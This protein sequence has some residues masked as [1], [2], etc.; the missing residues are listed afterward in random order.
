MAYF[1]TEYTIHFDDTMAYGS[2]HFL[3]AFKLQCASRESFLFGEGIF[4]V[5]GVREALDSV[6]LLT[7]DAYARNL[8]P[9]RLGDRLAILLSLEEWGQASARFC[10]RVMG[11]QGQAVCAGFQTL[12]CVDASTQSPIPLP[13]ALQQAVNA[14]RDIAE[15]QAQE[16]FRKRVLS[17]RSQTETLFGEIE[18]ETCRQ[19]FLQRYPHP[20]LV[21]L[22][23][24]PGQAALKQQVSSLPVDAAPQ[25]ASHNKKSEAW[26]FGGQATF[27]AQIFCERIQAYANSDAPARQ[28]LNECREI[29]G[30]LLGGDADGLFSASEQQCMR[31][32]KS[33]PALSQVGIHLQNVL[34]AHLW[35]TLGHTPKFLLGH[36]FGEV[37]AFGVG[38]CFDL[39]T[40]VRIVC[41]RMLAVAELA[42]ANAGLLVV[43]C[44]RHTAEV[45]AALLGLDQVVF[46]GRNHNSQLVMSGPTEQLNRLK[47]HL[48]SMQVG[49]TSI[50][51]PTSFHHPQLRT[52]ASKWLSEL[53]RL[54]L[55]PPSLAIYSPISQR[56]ISSTDD[57]PALLASQLTLPFDL[58]SAITELLRVGVTSFVDCGSAG[59][60]ARLI[61][62][63]VGENADVQ[64][65]STQRAEAPLQATPKLAESAH[66][67]PSDPPEIGNRAT[68]APVETGARKT[69]IPQIAIVGAGCILPGGVSSPRDLFSTITEQRVGIVD[70]RDFDPF[71]S[72][73]FYSAELKPDRSNSHLFGRIR[74]SDIS[75][76]DGVDRHIFSRFTRTQKLLC[77]ALAPC[78]ASLQ[79]AQRVICLLGSTADGFE[80]QDEVASLRHAGIDP[81]NPDVE[82]RM[83]TARS[84]FHSPHS[85]VQEVVDRIVGPGIKVTLVDAA[86]A[87]SLY[88]LA[89]GMQA[90]ESNQ[91]DAVIAGG[92]FCPGPG[93][94][95][96][97]SQF[98]GT[99]STGCRPFDAN[100]DGVVFS[101]GAAIV[102]LRRVGDAERFDLP[103]SAIV[104][105]AG[106]SSDGRSPSANVPQSKGQLLSLE[107]CYGNYGIDPASIIAIEGHGTSTPVGDATELATLRSFF[108][109]NHAG[110]I[111]V[112]SLKGLLGHAGWA[113]GTASVI[114][115]CEYLRNGLFPS[116]ATFRQ[117]SA[118]LLESAGTL[119][120]STKPIALPPL[121]GRIAIDGFGFGGANAHVVLEHYDVRKLRAEPAKPS[122][123]S[124][125]LDGDELVIVA[126]HAERPIG[127]T[128]FE[129]DQVKAPKKFIMLPQLVDDMDISQTLAIMVCD[130][131]L[132]QIPQFDDVMR[133]ETGLLLAMSGKT[134]RGIEATLRIMT[135]RMR[136]ILH[137]N[138]Q[139]LDRLNKAYNI[140]RPSGAYTLQCMMPNVASGRA[141]LLL[142]LNGPN[143]VVDAGADSLEAAFTAAALLLGS[144]D[145]VGTKMVL[146]TAIKIQPSHVVDDASDTVDDGDLRGSE[147]AAAYAVTT[148]HFAQV[149]G[150]PVICDVDEVFR[151]NEV[152]RGPSQA[153]LR[154]YAQFQALQAAL[155]NRSRTTPQTSEQTMGAVSPMSAVPSLSQPVAAF[156]S[157]STSLS[158]TPEGGDCEIQV[159]VW[160]EKPM[161]NPA[162]ETQRAQHMLVIV[163]AGFERLPELRAALPQ[164][165]DQSTIAVVGDSAIDIVSATGQSNRIAIDMRDEQLLTSSLQEICCPSVDVV[166][167][168][169][170]A[171]SWDLQETLAEIALNNSLCELLFLIAKREVARLESGSIEM[172]GVLIDAWNG[173]AHPCS[174]PIAGL[175]KS[176][177]REFP[178]TRSGTICTQS[179]DVATALRLLMGERAQP[180]REP[181]LVFGPEF[182]LVRRL[183]PAAIDEDA[184]AQVTLDANSVVVAIGGAKGVTAVMLDSLLCEVPCT[185]IAIGRSPLE[186]GPDNFDTAEVEQT[187]YARFLRENPSSS[188]I[189]MRRS[190]EA[191][192][193]RWEAHQ[194]VEQLASRGGQV[195]YMVA[196]VTD[197]EQLAATVESIVSRF[198]KIDLLLYGAGVQKSKRLADRSLAD[199]REVFSTK[200]V[201]LH[202][203]VSA[204]Y[205]QTGARPAS[206]VLTSAYS[207]FGNDGQH[208]YGAANE[209][210]DRL[211]SLTEGDEESG[212]TSIAWL[213]WDGIGM[214]RG[215]E[216]QALAKQ[217]RLS[218]VVPEIGQRIFCEVLSGRTRSAINVPM[219]GAEHIKYGVRT[220]PYCPTMTSGRTI[221]MNV[222]LSDIPCMPFH[223]IRDI[224][225]L[226][227]AWI[228]DLL[229]GAGKKLAQNTQEDSIVIVEDTSFAKFVRLSNDHEPNVRVVAQDCGNS[230]A[231]WMI[232]D[233]L[234]PS[235][236]TLAKDRICASAKLSWKSGQASTSPSMLGSQVNPGTG[237]VVR[238]PYC[239]QRKGVALSGPFDCLSDIELCAH[240]R[241]AKVKPSQFQTFHENI[242]AL[243]LDA[244]WRVGAMYTPSR[245]SDVF[246]PLSVGRMS[247]PLKSGPFSTSPSAWEIRSTTPIAENQNVLCDRMEVLDQNGQLQ[248]VIEGARAT[249]IA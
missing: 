57:I 20:Q 220:I 182:R 84:A 30:R 146:V 123:P 113:A 122:L 127:S 100:A 138:A 64:C 152:A 232:S 36:S 92:F 147:F 22:A 207:V 14:M 237:Q 226:P 98:R 94:S 170:E 240:S 19:F 195:E 163:K 167:V 248:M 101:E 77:V 236:V 35:R 249:C 200:V 211:C 151:P 231:V 191:A 242:P 59:V 55:R 56:L 4:D 141:A 194:T 145:R 148:R 213:A 159:P 43:S 10:Y 157:Q 89:L 129:R 193:G 109:A 83:H 196:D 5:A 40:G 81:C 181:E 116:Q 126:Y 239:E 79:G 184:P 219:S 37:A 111:P 241:R 245:T 135:E 39:A 115:A 198:G 117:P 114:A 13:L 51:S 107:R 87:S 212:W 118:A 21:S 130:K 73:D 88:S 179:L 235:G 144:R 78:V 44:D 47:R 206:H 177:S 104:A 158:N 24:R 11:Q 203:L 49:A 222:R 221:E 54:Q 142:N 121:G 58:Q 86:C 215:T 105:G 201:G 31:A 205:S 82:R 160:V 48:Q 169:D 90:L 66:V 17:G 233:V 137:G 199:F 120:V 75:V 187:Y 228:L 71:W 2:H 60:L 143:F 26:V 103:I 155:D 210:L 124:T 175:L 190:F 173:L 85:A 168:M 18:R 224:P 96:L 202:H 7:V 29:T 188:A 16:T 6:H 134:E 225:T 53:R 80:D 27:D 185:A 154:P 166:T 1:V 3:T 61:S 133:R 149:C 67:A 178:A 162:S 97:F 174:G 28:E 68:H 9:A 62:K 70:Q 161:G 140:A 34:G 23:D 33:T 192:R 119:T 52:A 183:R 76:P 172:W 238:D 42:P 229:I 234:H 150:L 32:V 165:A 153:G 214:T 46:A 110:P 8:S 243:L 41:T 136:R 65:V 128:R 125:I 176:I 247:L 15:P 230:V 217:R 171:I 216:Y 72:D 99:T 209:T 246:A 218:G 223:L 156:R 208:D 74:D 189:E 106:L 131:V 93:N 244:A 108:A 12:V 50:D 197:S 204:Y 227:G 132:Q 95:C 164:F 139:L 45:E 38:G 102:T 69:T 112:H 180:D 25:A 63:A 186:A 91:A